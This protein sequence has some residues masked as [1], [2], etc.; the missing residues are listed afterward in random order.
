MNEKTNEV[1]SSINK[2]KK[3]FRN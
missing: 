1:G 3:I 2:E